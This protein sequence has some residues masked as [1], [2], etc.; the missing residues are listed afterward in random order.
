MPAPRAATGPERLVFASSNPGKIREVARLLRPSGREVVAQSE[1]G[2]EGV[3]EGG[4]T[5]VE[6]A[7]LKARAASAASGLPSIADDSGL[8]V[9]ALGGAPG[10]RSARLAGNGA[11]DTENVRTL[12]SLMEDIRDSGRGASFVC[13]AVYMHNAR[14]PVPIIGHGTWRGRILRAPQGEEGFGYDPVF[15]VAEHG[16]SVA[17]LSIETKNA[18]SHRAKAFGALLSQLPARGP[19]LRFKEAPP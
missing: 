17:E 18:S 10:V 2:V 1:F 3:E 4:E 12:L 15:H 11:S 9:D 7:I 13:V 14:D 8:M 16:V 19:R 6:N 5:F